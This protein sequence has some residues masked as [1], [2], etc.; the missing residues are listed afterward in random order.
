MSYLFV[1]SLG[2]FLILSFPKKSEEPTPPQSVSSSIVCYN[3]GKELSLSRIYDMMGVVLLFEAEL[4]SNISASLVL[5]KFQKNRDKNEAWIL[6]YQ[7]TNKTMGLAKNI[8]RVLVLEEP[9]FDG[10]VIEYLAKS[11]KNQRDL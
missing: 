1:V 9:T 7:R 8:C 5:Q 2:F 11:Y 4:N 6:T 10:Q 3:N